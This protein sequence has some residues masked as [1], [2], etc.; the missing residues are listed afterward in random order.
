MNSLIVFSHLRWNFVYQRPQHVL[1]RIAARWPVIF[2]EE[3]VSGAPS[4]RIEFIAAAPDVEVWRPHLRGAEQGMRATQK[5]TMQRLIAQALRQRRI[6]DYWVWFY[7]PMALPFAEALEPEGIIY[8]CMDELSMFKGAPPQL[9]EQETALFKAADI[10]FTGGR[11]LYNAKRSRHPNVYCFPSSV[12]A[13]HFRPDTPDHPLQ[14]S[15]PRPRLGYCGVIDERIDIELIA[16]IASSRP[17]WQIVMVGPTAKI[18]AGSL[19]QHKNIHWLGQQ[20]YADL[21]AFIN[22]WDVCL[23]PFALNDATRFIS[24]TKT[25]EYMACGKPSVSTAIR[26]VVEPYGHVVPIRADAEGFVEA[27]EGIMQRTAE[28]SNA[29]RVMVDGIIANTSWD[30]TASEMC[31]LIAD[32]QTAREPR[33]LMHSSTGLAADLLHVSGISATTAPRAIIS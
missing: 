2:I 8:D 24:P 30:A 1:S 18:D 21:P 12:D 20:S 6:D 15:L 31:D 32:L 27:C 19:P 29:Q 23:L 22:G 33:P 16:G 4:D 10:V 17:D 9:L 5:T 11:S 3:P 14:A 7:T 28:Q 26:D 13:L 25:L